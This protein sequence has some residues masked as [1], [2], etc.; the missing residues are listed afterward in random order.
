[1]I[2]LAQT[3]EYLD[4]SFTWPAGSGTEPLTTLT[5]THNKGRRPDVVTLYTQ[6]SGRWY[7]IPDANVSGSHRYGFDRYH[8]DT[9]T[10]NT[11]V[12]RIYNNLTLSTQPAY[13]RLIW[14][15]LKDPTQA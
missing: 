2:R 9:S 7:A 1:M 6:S 15:S 13:A 14:H 12:I 3:T 10:E 8:S 11:E 5:L 4:Y